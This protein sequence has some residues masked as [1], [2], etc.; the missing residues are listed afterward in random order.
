VEEVAFLA[1]KCVDC[2]DY[3][4]F[5]CSAVFQGPRCS[6]QFLVL[7]KFQC[8]DLG[9][10]LWVISGIEPAPPATPNITFTVRSKAEASNLL[11]FIIGS[12]FL[13]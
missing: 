10:R 8:G 11:N 9:D 2:D 1:V 3:I 5:A 12:P 13:A 6:N 7:S 4:A